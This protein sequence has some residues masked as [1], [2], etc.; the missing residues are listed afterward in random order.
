MKGHA[1]I[2]LVQCFLR[3]V[4]LLLLKSGPHLI[5]VA[6]QRVANVNKGI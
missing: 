1:L 3:K 4:V 2:K 5:L 6:W